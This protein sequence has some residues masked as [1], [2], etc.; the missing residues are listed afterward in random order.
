M[1]VQ[2]R[3]KTQQNYVDEVMQKADSN[4]SAGT[5]ADSEQKV[6]DTSVSQHSRKQLC[7]RGNWIL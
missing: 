4:S 3:T 7:K 6:E 1:F 2:P 5:K